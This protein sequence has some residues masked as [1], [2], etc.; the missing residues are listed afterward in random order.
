LIN[1]NEPGLVKP[2]TYDASQ[3]IEL[4]N[5]LVEPSFDHFADWARANREMLRDWFELHNEAWARS[6]QSRIA[7]VLL[8]NIELIPSGKF[9]SLSTE[10]EL[11]LEQIKF[12]FD[13]VLRFPLYGELAGGEWYL[14]HPIRKAFKVNR[15]SVDEH[16]RPPVPLSF[17]NVAWDWAKGLSDS[18]SFAHELVELR[19][20]VWKS[21]LQNLQPGEFGVETV[22]ELAAKAGLP[23]TLKKV[24]SGSVARGALALAGGA[25]TVAGGALSLA[26][27]AIGMTVGAAG[28]AA[29]MV[30]IAGAIWSGRL[31]PASGRVRFLRWALEWPELETQARA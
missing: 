24:V 12:A 21:G 28:A 7:P 26:N 5:S 22:R 15:M 16:A 30:T 8:Y 18:E 13:V 1:S 9:H 11:K 23:P 31:P 19:N 10:T 29:G 17:K 20:S 2:V 27:P 4:E 3:R 14:D 6:H 25:I